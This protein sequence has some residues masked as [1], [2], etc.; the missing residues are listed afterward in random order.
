MSVV[1]GQLV[2]Q[3]IS[4]GGVANFGQSLRTFVP[5]FQVCPERPAFDYVGRSAPADSLDTQACPGA[6][7][8]SLRIEVE[9]SLR[10]FISPEYFNLPI[11]ISG[12]TSDT[13]FG[14]MTTTRMN[15]FGYREEIP[16]PV[17]EIQYAGMKNIN[18]E[19]LNMGSLAQKFGGNANVTPTISEV[20]AAHLRYRRY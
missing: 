10:P 11:G 18:S 9:N 2:Q 16:I 17:D 4:S 15:A 6:Y 14:Q 3:K 5:Q 12:G 7:P 13:M 1:S 20:P 19:A 8:S